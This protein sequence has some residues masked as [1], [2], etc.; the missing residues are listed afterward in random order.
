MVVVTTAKVSEVPK[1]TDFDVFYRS[2]HAPLYRA[3]DD[4]RRLRPC[5]R[6]NR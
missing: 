1:T 3:L 2:E 4:P 5:R 6:S